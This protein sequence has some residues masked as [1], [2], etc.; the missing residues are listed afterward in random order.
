MRRDGSM[1][2]IRENGRNDNVSS[3]TIPSGSNGGSKYRRS[4][5]EVKRNEQAT[6]H[7]NRSNPQGTSYGRRGTQSQ[8]SG[9]P[10]SFN[11]NSSSGFNNA[12]SSRNSNSSG[13][14]R[15]GGSSYRR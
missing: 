10:A 8:S 14:G 7:E 11:R 12:G 4:A 6:R 15:S 1:T 13:G 9:A 3:A 2:Q 5:T